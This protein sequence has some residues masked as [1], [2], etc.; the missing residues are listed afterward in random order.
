MLC[1]RGSAD[2]LMMWQIKLALD[3]GSILNPDKVMQLNEEF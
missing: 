2:G 1:L 3:P